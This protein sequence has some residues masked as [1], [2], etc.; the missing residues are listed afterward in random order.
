MSI[1]ISI[2]LIGGG[3]VAIF[4]IRPKTQNNVM[5]MK[6]MQTK[7]ISELQDMFKKW[8]ILV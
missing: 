8:M 5:E 7:K 6:Y 1:L 4:Y 3:L 2:L